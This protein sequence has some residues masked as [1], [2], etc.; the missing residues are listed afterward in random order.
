MAN[1]S[2]FV[3]PSKGRP[4]ALQRAATVES[5]TG[6][7]PSRIREPAVVGTPSVVMQSLSAIG[8]PWPASPPFR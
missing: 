4:A 2:M 6:T 5:K 3:L 8:T 7:Y 1:S